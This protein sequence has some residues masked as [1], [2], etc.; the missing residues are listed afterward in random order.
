MFNFKI[1]VFG[2][3]LFNK[4]SSF[5]QGILGYLG[6]EMSPEARQKVGSTFLVATHLC[7]GGG[8]ACQK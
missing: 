7:G 1:E 4:W 5:L 8:R 2:V 3:F 6:Y